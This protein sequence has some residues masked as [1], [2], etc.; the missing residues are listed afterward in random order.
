MR[1]KLLIVCI[2]LLL[3][4]AFPQDVYRWARDK[5]GDTSIPIP[6]DVLRRIKRMGVAPRSEIEF[7]TLHCCIDGETFTVERKKKIDLRRH[8]EHKPRFNLRPPRK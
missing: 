8:L 7:D 3:I 2:V 6:P 5:D 4:A 1:R